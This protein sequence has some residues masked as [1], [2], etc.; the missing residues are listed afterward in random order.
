[1]ALNETLQGLDFETVTQVTNNPI[2][3]TAIIMVISFFV[4][5][6]LLKA[7]DSLKDYYQLLFQQLDGLS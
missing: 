1:M 2:I 4:G 7:I 3:L 5:S 6:I